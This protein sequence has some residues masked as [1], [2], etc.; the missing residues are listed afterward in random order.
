MLLLDCGD[1]T[2]VIIVHPLDNVDSDLHAGISTPHGPAL[3]FDV[4][5][6]DRRPGEIYRRR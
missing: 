2:R 3:P 4:F 5:N 1:G 6:F